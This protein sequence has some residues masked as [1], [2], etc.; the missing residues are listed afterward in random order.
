L[1]VGGSSGQAGPGGNLEQPDYLLYYPFPITVSCFV[2]FFNTPVITSLNESPAL[3][4]LF[5]T[6]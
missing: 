3:P 5:R 2:T 4:R 1:G 6:R